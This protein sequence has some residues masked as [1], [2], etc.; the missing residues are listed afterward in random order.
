MEVFLRNLHTI[1]GNA[2]IYGFSI[3]GQMAHETETDAISFKEGNVFEKETSD[4][5]DFLAQLYSLRGQ[6][7]EYFFL[8]RD[9]FGVESEDDSRF[10]SE[11][12]ELTKDLEFWLGQ[13]YFNS[14]SSNLL[15]TGPLSFLLNIYE[16]EEDKRLEIFSSL[17]RILHSLKGLSESTPSTISSTTLR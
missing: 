10:K 15:L 6:I 16:L 2:R 17:K 11:V 14:M 5:D 4:F 13:T 3:I 9:I 12:H 8:A 1:K 7:N